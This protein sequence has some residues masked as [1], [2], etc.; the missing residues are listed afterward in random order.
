MLRL[1]HKKPKQT[2]S[3]VE[4]ET[5]IAEQTKQVQTMTETGFG[6]IPL[7]VVLK[8]LPK[9]TL[10]NIHIQ[11]YYSEKYRRL[12]ASDALHKLNAAEHLLRVH[13][14]NHDKDYIG[15][16]PERPLAVLEI[17]FTKTRKEPYQ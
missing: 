16:N 15:G 2:S 10:V 13:H 4:Q 1:F 14:I 6:G 8:N 5:A 17:P 7:C 9:D 11:E 3:Y 12:T